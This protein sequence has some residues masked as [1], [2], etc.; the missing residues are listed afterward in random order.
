MKHESERIT[1]LNPILYE[2]TVNRALLEDLGRTGDI[3]TG[4]VVSAEDTATAEIVAQAPGR[5][6]G[7]DIAEFTFH[8][9]DSRLLFEARKHD[10][11][12][13]A[14]GETIAVIRGNPG[15]I[16]TGERTA[17]NFLSHLSGIATATR[18][19]VETV[20]PYPA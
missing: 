10:G 20:M 12:D 17:L 18:E 1:P 15:S 8:R 14:P 5:I 11:M 4:A 19:I 13:V 7:M 9:L 3:T 6:A 16:L 2:D